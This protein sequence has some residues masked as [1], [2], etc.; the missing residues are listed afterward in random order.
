ML[1]SLS[2]I[3][4]IFFSLRGDN[5]AKV[6]VSPHTLQPHRDRGKDIEGAR[7]WDDPECGLGALAT[8]GDTHY[9]SEIRTRCLCSFGRWPIPV[10]LHTRFEVRQLEHG[11]S[12]SHRTCAEST[13]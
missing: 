3:R 11:D 1:A 2:S 13:D 6:Y 12:L 9:C 4:S 10:E 7:V 5:H 8:S